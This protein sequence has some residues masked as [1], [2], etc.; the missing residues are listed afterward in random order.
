VSNKKIGVIFN[1]GLGD[2][3]MLLPLIQALKIEGYNVSIIISTKYIS[4][5]VLS[6]FE[7]YGEINEI[8]TSLFD[9]VRFSIARFRKFDY[10]LVSFT[11]SSL[12]WIAAASWMS[13]FVI[14][15]RKK[16]YL[17]LFPTL[18]FQDFSGIEHITIQNIRL[19]KRFLP[20]NNVFLKK[21]INVLAYIGNKQDDVTLSPID[22]DHLF[23]NPCFAVQLSAANN[24]VQYKNWKTENWII[25]FR[26][27][28]EM[29]PEASM[30]LIGDANETGYA[31]AVMGANLK[32]ISSL[33]GQTSLSDMSE[34]L[35]KCTLYIGLDSGLMQMAAFLGK[36]TFT[37]WGPTE[38]LECGYQI[39]DAGR[40]RDICL[41]L[42]CHPCKSNISPNT[43]RFNHPGKCPDVACINNIEP[44]FVFEEF[45][46]FYDNLKYVSYSDDLDMTSTQ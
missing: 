27:V 1:T 32:N 45:M 7:P 6:S 42:P 19:A 38:P 15:N 8:G 41:K 25:F 31:D 29:I 30:I 46:K 10:F 21:D 23:R 33:V 26:M 20:K 18:L 36:P 40:H 4:S 16:W 22:G 2:G 28:N 14:T 43:T 13:K 12:T 5:D 3:L 34:I 24:Q 35:T 44:L 17:H 11:S 39:I 9:I 37:I